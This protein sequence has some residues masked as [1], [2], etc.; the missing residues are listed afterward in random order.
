MDLTLSTS[1]VLPHLFHSGLF[2]FHF[3]VLLLWIHWQREPNWIR[4]GGLSWFLPNHVMQAGYWSHCLWACH[5]LREL[6]RVSLGRSEGVSP[7]GVAEGC[8]IAQGLLL[9]VVF[10]GVPGRLPL[11]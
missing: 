10:M 4:K 2:Q 7:V 3:L 11:A 8:S 1:K 9:P 6:D 5:H